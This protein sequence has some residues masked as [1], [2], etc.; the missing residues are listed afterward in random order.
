MTTMPS[1]VLSV[2]SF[3]ISFLTV[4]LIRQRFRQSLLDIPNE[5]SSHTQPTPRGGGLG[6]IIAF[7]ITS[8]IA[9]GNNYVH[10]FADVPLNLNLAIVWLILIP[11]AIVG[12]LD[13][14]SNVPAGIRY[15]VQ[16]VAAGVAVTYFGAFPQPWLSQFGVVGSIVAIVLTAIGMTAIVNFYN[17][18][19]G[20]DGIVAGTSAIQLGFFA[21]YLHHPLLWFLVAAL[22]GFLWWNWSPAKIFMGDAGSTVLGA[23]VAIALLNA[24]DSAVQAWS[25][26]AVTLPLVGDAI[27]TILR[28]LLKR[29]NIFQAHRSHLYQRLQQSGWSHG[30]VAATYMGITLAIALVVG[31]YGL[32][33]AIVGAIGTVAAGLGGEIYMRSRPIKQGS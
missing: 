3:G 8:A 11:L 33:G 22:V 32:K 10:L 14:R 9:M 15:L 28:R 20:L 23:T 17:F 26:L 13:D 6:F 29:E 27:Y 16:L 18:M 19:D 25:A 12:I 30:R 5:R 4:N 31:F 7:A 24:G 2:F 1:I 21:F